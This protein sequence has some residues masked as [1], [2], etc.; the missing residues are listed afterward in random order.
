MNSTFEEIGEISTKLSAL[1]A[2]RQKVT[3]LLKT[4]QMHNKAGS[5]MKG[6]AIIGYCVG[7]LQSLLTRYHL[8]DS[9]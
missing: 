2:D 8:A 6:E 4:I 5:D 9:F 7:Y 3:L 1:A